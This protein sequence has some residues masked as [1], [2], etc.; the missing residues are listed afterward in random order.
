MI[1]SPNDAEPI[2]SCSAE[3]NPPLPDVE[4]LGD[5][6]SRNRLIRLAL[7]ER[8]DDSRQSVGSLETCGPVE[9]FF[10]SIGRFRP[11]V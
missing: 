11:F 8:K 3:D 1:S 4:K 7:L 6:H 2:V 5:E 10:N 9:E